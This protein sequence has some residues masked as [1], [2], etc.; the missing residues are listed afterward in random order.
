MKNRLIY[1]VLAI[2]LA[3]NFATFGTVAWF[4][5][6]QFNRRVRVLRQIKRFDPNKIQPLLETYHLQM[7]SLRRE[8]WRARQKLAW[9]ALEENPET[10]EVERTLKNIGEIHQQMNRLVYEIGRETG[11]ILPPQ[12]R[13]RLCQGWHRIMKGPNPPPDLYPGCPAPKPFRKIFRKR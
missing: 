2:S 4:R 3:I 11:M 13:K 10:A 5:L 8:Y 9:L 12:H 7:D 6:R 1:V